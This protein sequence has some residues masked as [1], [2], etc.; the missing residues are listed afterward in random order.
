MVS[1][2]LPRMALAA[3][4]MPFDSAQHF[5]L[6]IY[7]SGLGCSFGRLC[8]LEHPGNSALKFGRFARCLRHDSLGRERWHG[9]VAR[10]LGCDVAVA[11]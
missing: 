5:Q 9:H 8:N 7:G 11:A 1:V 3:I 6:G 2:V 10:G 4:D